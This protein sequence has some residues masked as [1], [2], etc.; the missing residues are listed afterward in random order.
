MYQGREEWV[1]P[2]SELIEAS[3]KLKIEEID[4]NSSKRVMKIKD[5]QDERRKP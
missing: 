3:I 2:Y 1:Y 5:I 4:S